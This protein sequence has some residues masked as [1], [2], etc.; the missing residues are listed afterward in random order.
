MEHN[1]NWYYDISSKHC[2]SQRGEDVWVLKNLMVPTKGVFVDVGA[3]H[4]ITNSNTYVFEQLGWTGLAIDGNPK[5]KDEWAKTRPNTK[6]IQAIVGK[7]DGQDVYFDTHPIDEISSI[8]NHSAHG[9]QGMSRNLTT[10]LEE[11]QITKI[12]LLS[13]DVEGNELE[14]LE[15][16]NLRRHQPTIVIVEYNTL[17]NYSFGA[18]ELLIH[19]GYQIRHLTEFNFILT[20][21]W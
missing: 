21:I 13:V 7:W 2:S 8:K 1:S 6:W 9:Y 16:L 4:P 12:D 19:A 11:N 15:G 5:W 18:I 3:A 10:L 20:K 14:V 17:G